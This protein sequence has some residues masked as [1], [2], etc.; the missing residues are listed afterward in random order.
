M[1]SIMPIVIEAEI[2]A[3]VI[4]VLGILITVGWALIGLKLHVSRTATL[5]FCCGNLLIVVGYLAALWR[6]FGVSFIRYFESLNPTDIM[7]M[8]T[9]L[10]FQLGLR[11]LYG[12][13][14]PL[15]QAA[16]HVAYAVLP[17]LL[18]GYVL[19]WRDPVAIGVLLASSWFA[20]RAFFESYRNMGK[21]FGAGARLLLLWPL[22]AASILFLLRVTDDASAMLNT[23]GDMSGT[24]RIKYFNM[25]L[26]TG[27]LIITLANASLIGQTI[28]GLLKRLNDQTKRL[29]YILDTAPVG[30]AIS[31]GGKIRFANRKLTHMLDVK[32]GDNAAK[33]LVWPED[34]A[35][36]IAELKSDGAV[37]D[38]ELQMRGPECD[39]RDLLVSYLPMDDA[40]ESGVLGWMIDITER[41]QASL[42]LRQLID[43]QD[44]VFESAMLGIALVRDERIVRANTQLEQL[45]GW[46]SGE[47]IGQPPSVWW[48]DGTQPDT[49][50]WQEIGQGQTHQSTQELC[51]KDG[52][53]FWCRLNGNLIDRSNPRLGT[54]WV[55]DD[56]SAERQAMR[57][58][59]EAKDLAEEATRLKSNFLANM[60]HEIRTPMNAIIGMSHLA[61][62]TD[63]APKQRNYIEKVDA[64]ARNLLGVINDILD[65]SKIEA[66]KLAFEYTPFVLSDVLDNLADISTIKAHDRGLELLFDV[67]PDVPGALMGDPMR[68][69]QVLLNLVGNAIK[70]TEHGEI[71]L[72][73]RRAD[74]APGALSS[75]STSTSTK[76][77]HKPG[78]ERPAA[79]A[80]WLRFDISDTGVGLTQDQIDRLF[81]AFSQADTSTTRKYGGTGLGLSICKRLVELMQGEM[82]VVSQSGVGSTFSF[83][84]GF[85]L[86][87]E[88]PAPVVLEPELVGLR[89]LLIDD[90]ARARE[91]ML[92]TL[93]AQQF[94][95][96]AVAN[97]QTALAILRAAARSEQPYRLVLVDSVMPGMDGL[98]TIARMRATPELAH[99]PALLMVAAYSREE[100]QEQ[101]GS[102]RIDGWLTKP[103]S[104]SSLFDSILAAL[105]KQVAA[106]G[107]KAQRQAINHSDMAHLAGAYLLLVEDNPLNQELALAILQEAGI[108]VDVA[109]HGMQALDMV[110]RNDY[111]GVLMD[112]QM[113]VMDG[114]EATRQIRT[115]PRFAPLPILAMTANAMQGD[116]ELCLQAGMNDHISKPI[117]VNQLFATLAR[118]ITPKAPLSAPSGMALPATEATKAPIK[119]PT[120]ATGPIKPVATIVPRQASLAQRHAATVQGDANS[121]PPIPRIDRSTALHHMGGNIALLRKL[122]LRF[123]VTRAD[124]MQL[125]QDALDRHDMASALREAHTT[126]GLAANFGAHELYARAAELETALSSPNPASIAPACAAMQ[127]ELALLIGQIRQAMGIEAMPDRGGSVAAD[128]SAGAAAEGAAEGA[129]SG[130]AEGAAGGATGAVICASHRESTGES[131]A[132]S[133]AESASASACTVAGPTLARQFEQLAALLRLDDPRATQLADSMADT[134]HGS[135]L[136]QPW[137]QL[138]KLITKYEFDSALAKLQEI[139]TALDLSL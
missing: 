127:Q 39:M 139:A 33:V 6:P 15:H 34:R 137:Q 55:F 91:I 36:V 22:L 90:N 20:W 89:I 131:G 23:H 19:H 74:G 41:K 116:K 7:L 79:P 75:A 94:Q 11:H 42:A 110:Q 105:G 117:D 32:V 87:S 26:W 83:T 130:A 95:A 17:V 69:G 38:M 138:C 102:I 132:E 37:H 44:A 88:Q 1:G 71:T 114:F 99:L 82:A 45:F 121:L 14:C 49:P 85:G 53:L 108:R 93:T 86:Q 18:F 67:A 73:I 112:C 10:L 5:Y 84:A 48:S 78:S 12:Q 81:Q 4:V 21:S 113:P 31:S 2:I 68:L 25:Y 70:F 54:V 124:T 30:V 103:V 80:L 13:P 9:T 50:P 72:A 43:E 109:N 98:T 27:F 52:S 8:Q 3:R 65:F 96:S 28:N 106:P 35:R 122:L 66:G 125:I 16:R 61:L 101:A 119:A 58:M 128:E 104:P 123:V 47:M 77:A 118:W 92:A 115:E 46:E 126:K 120:K 107:R 97:G 24:V 135:Q 62:N 129:A 59:R 111:D 136:A 56:V 63:L 57:L 134:L 60:S 76:P 133:G 64:A 100:W 40:D 51:K 29:Q